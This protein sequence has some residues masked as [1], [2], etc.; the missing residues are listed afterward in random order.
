MKKRDKQDATAAQSLEKLKRLVRGSLITSGAS[1]RKSYRDTGKKETWLDEIFPIVINE[2]YAFFLRS[3]G[4]L[5]IELI[6]SSNGNGSGNLLYVLA[7]ML[8]VE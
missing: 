5:A 4:V 8:I 7:I 6:T 3:N 1:L 2:R